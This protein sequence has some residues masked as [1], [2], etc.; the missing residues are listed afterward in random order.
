MAIIVV[1]IVVFVF[2][3][4]IGVQSGQMLVAFLVWM[5]IA[6]IVNICLAD[7]HYKTETKQGREQ[8]R[9]ENE[10]NEKEW[11]GWGYLQD[12]NKRKK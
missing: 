4:V 7:A 5:L 6:A 1:N 12:L 2:M 11:N 10:T 3:M 9:R 8:W